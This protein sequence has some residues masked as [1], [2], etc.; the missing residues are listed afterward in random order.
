MLA[1]TPERVK[2]SLAYLRRVRPPL[3]GADYHNFE[4]HPVIEEEKVEAFELSHSIRLPSQYREFLVQIGNG[5]AGPD[6]GVFSLGTIDEGFGIRAW[7][8]NGAVV[9]DPSKPFRFQEAWNDTSAK[10]TDDL[11]NEA[12]YWRL[13]DAF[14]G[15]YWSSDLVNGAIP[16]C[17][18]GCA[19]RIWLVVNGPESGKLWEDRRS[20]F[21][22]ISPLKLAD[23]SRATFGAWY[24]TWLQKCLTNAESE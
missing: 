11:E 13:M 22:G 2:E 16:I 8:A 18:R 9:G 7:Q 21:D 12:E 19:I 3:F 10:P 5:G 14:E 23:G 24:D 17:H 4:L 1:L 15:T 20:E 6:Y